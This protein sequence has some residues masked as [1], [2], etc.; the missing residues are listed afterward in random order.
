M[1]TRSMYPRYEFDLTVRKIGDK[2]QD[3]DKYYYIGNN[4]AKEPDEYEIEVL[5]YKARSVKEVLRKLLDYIKS[6]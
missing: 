4:E 1:A 5:E 6:L 3:S 2:N